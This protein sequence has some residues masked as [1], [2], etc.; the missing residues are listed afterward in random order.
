ME[1]NTD[2]TDF[3]KNLFAYLTSLYK[4]SKKHFKFP[5]CETAIIQTYKIEISPKMTKYLYS[6]FPQTTAWNSS[7]V[8]TLL[9]QH[10]LNALKDKNHR[11]L[12]KLIGDTLNDFLNKI[13]IFGLFDANAMQIFLEDL[14]W[15]N[16]SIILDM[17][18]ELST[19][20]SKTVSYDEKILNQNLQAIY[21]I[22]IIYQRLMYH[23]YEMLDLYLIEKEE[24]CRELRQCIFDRVEVKHPD[25]FSE[26]KR[27]FKSCVLECK[28]EFKEV[29][30]TNLAGLY[31]KNPNIMEY[32]NTYKSSKEYLRS[33][34][35][36]N[37]SN[38]IGDTPTDIFLSYYFT[39]IEQKIAESIIIDK[40][41]RYVL[42][43]INSFKDGIYDQLKII[44]KGFSILNGVVYNLFDQ[45]KLGGRRNLARLFSIFVLT[46][47]L[48]IDDKAYSQYYDTLQ[49]IYLSFGADLVEEY[50]ILKDYFKLV[51]SKERIE[52]NQAKIASHLE[53]EKKIWHEQVTP[54]QNLYAMMC[55][56]MAFNQIRDESTIRKY[57]ARDRYMLKCIFRNLNNGERRFTN[58]QIL[59]A[60][61]A[62]IMEGTDKTSTND[63]K[64]NSSESVLISSGI[65]KQIRTTSINS[66]SEHM[67]YEKQLEGLHKNLNPHLKK[68]GKFFLEKISDP[69]VHS[70]TITIC[71]SGYTSEESLKSVEW[72]NMLSTN[73]YTEMFALNWSSNSSSKL[74]TSLFTEAPQIGI[75]SIGTS[76]ISGL[77]TGNFKNMVLGLTTYS[78]FEG[79]KDELWGKTYEEAITTGVYLA[80]ILGET[81]LFKDHVINLVGFSLGTL[82]VMNCILELERMN[83]HDIVYDVLLMGGVV[84]AADFNKA[85]WRVVNHKIINCYCDT[86]LILKFLLK[87]V[88]YSINPIGLSPI[89]SASKKVENVDVSKQ[90]DGHTKY[91][92]H[93]HDIMMRI[94]FNEDFNYLLK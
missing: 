27:T 66:F 7:D 77:L 39:E 6:R 14:V 19:E 15:R 90:A 82:V 68:P 55:L 57:T 29:F 70:K 1:D 13:N 85:A 54:F 24:L 94:D 49:T 64:A 16:D 72:V 25:V 51:S 11:R 63:N 59:C 81:K 84:N 87:V 10:I 86:D 17:A 65:L 41:K 88:D 43:D 23:K 30:E 60:M 76:I 47:F 34:F 31:N 62:L 73:P 36:E 4:K 32:V 58:F 74:M 2:S 78:A 40:L 71:V 80:H 67:A 5:T 26:N 35:K 20:T 38:A 33:V 28:K 3:Y 61:E 9:E 12:K 69:A 21:T 42:R 8:E 46:D 44:F 48:E 22:L 83:R 91:R 18:E 56:F 79:I 45:K 89:L 52:M 93:L 37:A 92:E 75:K 53:D 50:P